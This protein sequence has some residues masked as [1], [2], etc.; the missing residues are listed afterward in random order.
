LEWNVE[1]KMFRII[2]S[3]NLLIICDKKL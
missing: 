2:N 1:K 3:N